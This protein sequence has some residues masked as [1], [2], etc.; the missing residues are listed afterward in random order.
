LSE[1]S[2]LWILAVGGLVFAQ[3][4][5]SVLI[6]PG[7]ALTVFSDVT[8][9]ILLLSATAALL[10]NISQNQ[11]RT[12]LFWALM[13]LGILFLLCRKLPDFFVRMLFWLRGLG[14]FRVKAVGMQNLPMDG[15]V[16]L[17][18]NG[19]IHEEMRQA[20]REISQRDPAAPLR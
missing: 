20:A 13:T 15:P 18:T 9:C 11:G 17:A 1:R 8:Q 14:H 6:K 4:Y 12:R 16:I 10:P 5:G 2:K 19:T 3:A 7:F